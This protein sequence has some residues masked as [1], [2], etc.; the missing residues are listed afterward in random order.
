MISLLTVSTAV[1]IVVVKKLCKE[2]SPSALGT[3]ENILMVLQ[4]LPLLLNFDV[5]RNDSVK[6]NDV[7]MIKSVTRNSDD[8]IVLKVLRRDLL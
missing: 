1:V 4:P 2:L 3:S 7:P 5:A 8:V 6:F